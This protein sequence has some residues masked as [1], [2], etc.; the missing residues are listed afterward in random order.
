MQ[1]AFTCTIGDTDLKKLF[2]NSNS[3][4][5]TTEIKKPNGAKENFMNLTPGVPNTL[6]TLERKQRGFENLS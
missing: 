4:H 2:N 5:V 3:S 6:K 1:N